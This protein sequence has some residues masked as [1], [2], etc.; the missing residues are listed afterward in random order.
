MNS[1]E[2]IIRAMKILVVDDELQMREVV[3]ECLTITTN[4]VVVSA[5]SGDDGLRLNDSER[6][7]VMLLDMLMP[8]LSG[9]SVLEAV[10]DHPTHHR[11]R[12]IVAMSG[13]TDQ[14][15]VKEIIRL[16]ADFVLAKPFTLQ[17]LRSAC[18]ASAR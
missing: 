3:E 14:E 6:P 11:P 15:T 7:D 1:G 10:K 4:C 18:E 17:E 8:G 9:F 13:I 5:A 16:G 12:K 2:G